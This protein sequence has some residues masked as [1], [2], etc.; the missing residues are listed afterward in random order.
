MDL[1]DLQALMGEAIET[2]EYRDLWVVDLGNTA[3][4]A[5]LLG[6]ARRMADSLGAYLHYVGPADSGEAIALG[7]DRVHPLAA[8]DAD[9]AVA[10]L[11]ALF[12]NAKP[13]FVFLAADE[14]GNEVA[15]R[16]AGRL[17]GGVV[18]NCIA[19][20]LDESARE[21]VASH[22]VYDGAH[23]LDSAVTAKPQIFTVRPE[24]FPTPA[25]DSGRTGE[26]EPVAASEPE[27]PSRDT[28]P[29]AYTPPATPLRKA[30]R[31]V[32]V[33]RGGNDAATVEVARL[34]A[35]KIGAH[36]AGDRSAFDSGWIGKEDIVGVIGTE[37][38]PDVYVAVGIWGDTM[39]R[40]GTEGAKFV[41]AIHPDAS[42]PIFKAADA[43][44]VG[45]PKD[46][47][48]KLLALL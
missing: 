33:G 45:Q 39:H 10:T 4:A 36:F 47:L 16:L 23:Y 14:T 3:R 35:A 28:G 44:V 20:R 30:A 13:E 40:A 12:A 5:P 41:V 48:P 43:A 25:R 19:L 42:A 29:A 34:L 9:A 24:I 6:E 8:A 38:A 22:P 11:A 18:L 32:A 17:H 31:V 37:I 27:H 7:A 1:N 15:A 46:V 21:V 26:V 2:D